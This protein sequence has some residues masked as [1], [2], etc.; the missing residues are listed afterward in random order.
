MANVKVY[1]TPT[2]PYCKRAKSLLDANGIDYETVD[3]SQDDQAIKE[4]MDKTGQMSVP[5]LDIDG[6][7]VIGFDKSKISELLGLS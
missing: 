2:C 6:E 4:M 3:V 7:L 5:V 1:S